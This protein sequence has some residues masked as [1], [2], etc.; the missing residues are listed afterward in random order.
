MATLFS[1]ATGVDI[2]REGADHDG[3]PCL[4]RRASL[5]RSG[6]DHPV[7]RSPGGVLGEG[8][9]PQR[10]YQGERIDSEKFEG[11]LDEYS[12]PEK[13]GQA[14]SLPHRGAG[15]LPGEKTFLGKN[16]TACGVGT[17]RQASLRG[18]PWSGSA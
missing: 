11:M 17:S 15:I 9:S 10:P 13:F 16:I 3:R 4:Q 18:P 14:G 12:Y 1:L 7:R 2:D 8:A 5:P 6:G